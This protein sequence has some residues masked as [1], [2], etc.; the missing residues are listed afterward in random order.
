MNFHL[1]E[2]VIKL[3]C[4]QTSYDKGEVYYRAG[5]VTITDYDTET[6]TYEAVVKANGK[7]EVTIKLHDNK[8][9][10]AKCSC[11][12]LASYDKY[13]SHVAAVLLNIQ[14]NQSGL[15][16]SAARSHR[17]GK[18]SEDSSSE[19]NLQDETG[20][21]DS[22]SSSAKD[23]KL[24]T[25]I[26]GLFNDKPLRPS[27]TRNLFDTREPLDVEFICKPLSY[28]NQKYMFAIEMK[29]GPKRLYMVQKLREFLDR[30]EQ[31][32]PFTF[33]KQ[34]TYDP[35]LHSFHPDNDAV[36]RALIQIDNNEKIYR[37]SSSI[38]QRYASQR[39][40][41]RMLPIAPSSWA[42]VHA[43]LTKAPMVKLEQE[44]SYYEGV[45]LSEEILPLR[46]EFEQGQ[47][48]EGYQLEVHGLDQIIVMDAYGVVISQGKLLKLPS[49]QCSRLS[50]L[51]QML[52]A[53]QTQQIQIGIEQIEPFM[54]KVIPGLMK[55]GS[56][57]IAENV[58]NRMVQTPL[59][60]KL[61]LDR[62]RDR[63]LA[64]LEFHYGSIVINPL[65]GTGQT[66]GKDRILMRDGEH[67]RRILEL[68]EQGGFTNTE[69]GYFLNDEDAEY[70]FL[71]RIIPQLEKLAHVYA[72]SAV[73]SKLQT[74][75]M[76]PKVNVNIEERTDWLICQFE[77]DGIPDSEIRNLIKSLE[78]KRKFHRMPNGSFM[79]LETEEYQE[80]IRFINETGMSKGEVLEAAIRFPVAH[81]LHLMDSQ[82]QGNTIKLGKSLRQLINNMRNPDHL[83]FPIPASLESVLRDYQ[84]VGFQWFKTLAHYHF[85]GVLADDM[86]LGK[87]VQ[88]IAFLVSVLPEIRKQKQPAIIVCPASLVYNWRNE[89]K[90]FA[91]DIRVAIADG[92]Q[93]ERNRILKN[94]AKVDVI[95]TSYPLLRRDILQVAKQV[96]HT[97]ILD[98]AQ[99][100][101]NH[102]TQTAQAVKAID[103]KYRFALT[104][105][106][107][108][109]KL[110]ELWSIFEAVFPALFPSRKGFQ[111]LT[112]ET[113]AKRVRPFLLRRLKS[114]VLKELPEKIESLQASE[115][116]PEQKKLYVAYLAKLQQETLKHLD[117]K[118]FQ[119]NRIKILAGLTRLRQLCCH[120][121]LFVEDYTGSSAKFE[122][123]FEMIEECRSAG[124]RLLV[125]SQFTEM[126]GL[127]GRELGSQ[128]V[129]F[130]YLDGKTAASERVELCHK[131]NEGERD[132][133]LISLKAGGTGLNLTGADTVI[134]Y[135]LWWNPAVEQQAADRAH[136]IG[137][138]KVVQVIRLVT[139][140]TV[141]DK[142][143]ELQQKKKN[144]IDEVIQP[145]QEALSSLSEQEIREILMIE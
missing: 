20:F 45:Q 52:E 46:Y 85:G 3:M 40:R 144:L 26:L 11:P 61:Y 69:G 15:S 86:G 79:P 117:Q 138:K 114:D 28:G 116:L 33:T 66:D 90:K 17:S 8:D 25:G 18:Q 57:H 142:M 89:L 92:N 39:D 6:A 60:A 123:L 121:A 80:I 133:F 21:G 34:F 56:V 135:D 98:E 97:L 101:K 109:N 100:F 126:L 68:M 9:L 104:G 36:I 83:D 59:K 7:E 77:I 127:I 115:L 75:L 107:V 88:S 102:A 29:V 84:K 82:R 139:Q 145:G 22:P 10:E 41:D 125:F 72:T 27:H 81:A 23:A 63:L 141:E 120:P 134:L 47:V 65:E 19:G 74:G 136:R 48:S 38:F 50:M 70:E 2:K 54:E 44:G 94:S 110:E 24:L 14:H 16:A 51:K 91:P 67:E 1:T 128:G 35:E 132:L 119:R 143:Y 4:G 103:A 58:S 93:E 13:C 131:F 99:F 106:P 12:T 96:F 53:S 5:K 130:F 32:E 43:L 49:E 64:G 124:R 118:D 30:I 113:I 87:T 78:E 76:P 105:T 137:Q 111:D 62:V 55:L 31:R 122:Q 42:D 112:R 140:G 129:P 95:I 108:E 73:K 37:E 71:Y